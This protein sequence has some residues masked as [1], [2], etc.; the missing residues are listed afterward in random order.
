MLIVTYDPKTKKRT[1]ECKDCKTIEK[2][3]EVLEKEFY[4]AFWFG[5][6]AVVLPDGSKFEIRDASSGYLEEKGR[7]RSGT[8]FNRK[9]AVWYGQV[10]LNSVG[11]P[12]GFTK[13]GLLTGPGVCSRSDAPS[14]WESK[15]TSAPSITYGFKGTWDCC[16]DLD[17]TTSMQKL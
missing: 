2:P 5:G 3:E 6:T 17:G 11:C 12:E 10:P 14:D 4:E 9:T 7:C 1:C 8:F 16:P 13:D 15:K